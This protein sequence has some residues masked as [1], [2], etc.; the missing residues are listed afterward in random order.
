MMRTPKISRVFV[1]ARAIIQPFV[2]KTTTFSET[3]SQQ[4]A[5]LDETHTI[6]WW[7]VRGISPRVHLSPNLTEQLET[8]RN[9]TN[10]CIPN[11][12]QG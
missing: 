2:L 4:A 1:V 8:L 11:F 10:R 9:D 6:F 7:E 3:K 12:S 5:M